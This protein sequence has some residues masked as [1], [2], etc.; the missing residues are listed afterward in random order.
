[1][2]EMCPILQKTK[3]WSEI[4]VVGSIMKW[5]LIS[6]INKSKYDTKFWHFDQS[7]LLAKVCSFQTFITQVLTGFKRKSHVYVL[8]LPVLTWDNDRLVELRR[9]LWATPCY[10]GYPGMSLWWCH[11]L[12]IQNVFQPTFYQSIKA[13][14]KPDKSI[15]ILL[16]HYGQCLQPSTLSFTKQFLR[17]IWVLS[18]C[19]KILNHSNVAL[20]SS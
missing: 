7:N 9:K 2:H 17:Y 19:I 20:K 6:Q 8:T 4:W 5:R 3:T 12:T 1:M 11:T 10:S 13:E 14:I 18:T 16:I 15:Q